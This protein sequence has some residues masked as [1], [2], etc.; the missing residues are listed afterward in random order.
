MTLQ[1]DICG[2]FISF[3]DLESG[4]ATR[5]MVSCDSEY[6]CEDYETLCPKHVPRGEL[7]MRQEST[8]DLNEC[9]PQ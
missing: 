4:R 8:S 6:S 9:W 7:P 5:K 1:C 3:D 2:H